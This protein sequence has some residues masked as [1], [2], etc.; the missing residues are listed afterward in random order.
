LGNEN[1]YGL[2]WAGA[3]TEDFPDEEDKKEKLEKTEEDRCI[4]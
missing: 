1:N 4:A 3:E 2:F